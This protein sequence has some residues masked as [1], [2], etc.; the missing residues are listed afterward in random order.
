MKTPLVKNIDSKTGEGPSENLNARA[1]DGNDFT[2]KANKESGKNRK[3]F[4][5]HET[6]PHVQHTH[7]GPWSQ[8][9]R[10]PVLRAS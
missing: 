10:T 4:T 9:H 1:S 5:P 6:A 2:T 3:I 8:Y 7:P